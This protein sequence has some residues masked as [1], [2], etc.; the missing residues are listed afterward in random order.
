MKT[1]KNAILQYLD[2]INS[3]G[4]AIPGIRSL[5][6]KFG[7]GSYS[8]FVEIIKEWQESKD[9]REKEELD[10]TT[11]HS[12]DLEGKMVS[13]ILP[14][15]KDRLKEILS[16]VYERSQ[17]EVL[18]ARRLRDEAIA[19]LDEVNRENQRLKIELEKASMERAAMNK[20]MADKIEAMAMKCAEEKQALKDKYEL[21]LNQ[22]DDLEKKLD[23]LIAQTQ[24]R[25]KGRPRKDKHVPVQT[26]KETE[27]LKEQ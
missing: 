10:E 13:A 11:L 17:V 19:E 23:A 8:T 20:T 6:E 26:I 24:T 9:K 18:T 25:P 5:R 27:V 4:E 2:E 14:V 15:L 1:N 21:Q 3:K 16:T 7:S 12:A 22:R